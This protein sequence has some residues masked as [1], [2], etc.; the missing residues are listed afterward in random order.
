M[1]RLSSALAI[2]DTS[3]KKRERKIAF[4]ESFLFINKSSGCL[5]FLLY[6]MLQARVPEGD[7]PVSGTRRS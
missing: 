2:L 1:K 7:Q 4:P 5:M 6:A 3:A